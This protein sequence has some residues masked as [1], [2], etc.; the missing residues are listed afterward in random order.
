MHLSYVCVIVVFSG[1]ILSVKNTTFTNAKQGLYVSISSSA[2]NVFSALCRTV[3]RTQLRS[4]VDF[5]SRTRNASILEAADSYT[6]GEKNGWE[7]G[8]RLHMSYEKS[9]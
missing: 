7:A 2:K 9:C 3:C 8:E 4:R 5:F 1:E 6:P